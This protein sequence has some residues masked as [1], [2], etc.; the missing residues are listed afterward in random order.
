MSRSRVCTAFELRPQVEVPSARLPHMGK[1]KSFPTIN[2]LLW[3]YTTSADHTV[4]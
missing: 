2:V 1:P 3:R 4:D